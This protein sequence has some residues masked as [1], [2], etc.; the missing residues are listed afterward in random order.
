MVLTLNWYNNASSW[1]IK[2]FGG[3]SGL[4]RLDRGVSGVPLAV[5]EASP[6]SFELCR[7][8]TAHTVN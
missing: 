6:D 8:E 5:C 2:P 4:M 7:V 1:F 3:R